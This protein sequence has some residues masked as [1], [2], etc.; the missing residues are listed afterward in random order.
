MLSGNAAGWVGPMLSGNAAGWVG[1][2]FGSA[3]FESLRRSYK[4]KM[5]VW[6]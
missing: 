4:V 5:K 6:L 3:V 1:P 2:T